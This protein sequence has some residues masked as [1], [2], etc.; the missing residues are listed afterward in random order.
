MFSEGMAKV[1]FLTFLICL[2]IAALAGTNYVNQRVKIHQLESSYN[3][4]KDGSSVTV[5][6]Y[7]T[8]VDDYT[9]LME[10]YE[11][12]LSDHTKVSAD[13]QKVVE[14]YNRIATYYNKLMEEE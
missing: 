10:D 3:I 13:L 11:K 12:L 6:K 8:L 9:K 7:N 14:D 2:F 5:G 1:W 4:L